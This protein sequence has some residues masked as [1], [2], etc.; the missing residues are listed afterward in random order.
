MKKEIKVSGHLEV[1]KGIYHMKL[2]WV[3]AEGKR[4]RKS[5]STELP[6]RGNKKRAQDMLIDFQREQEAEL[7]AN[8][9]SA[10]DI[11]F[12]DYMKQWLE[13]MKLQIRPTTYSGYH[14]NV[15]GVIIPYFKPMKLKLREVTPKHIQDFYTKQR[16]RVKGTTVK[17]YHAN[18]HKAFKDARKL[19]LIDSNPMECV[20]PP[21]KEPYHGQTYTVE[22]AQKILVLI[23]DTIFEI[24]ITMM[25]FYGLRREEAIG[26]KWQNID[27]DNDTF[28]IAHTVTETKVDG[29]LQM[30]KEDLTKN[31]SSYRSL[32]LVAPVKE[33]LL[34]KKQSIQEYRK[35]FRR[36]Y[37]RE[38]SDY[39]CV[40]EIGEL[41]KPRT[42]SDNFKRIIRQNKI[43]NLR[44][45][46]CRHTAASLML[47]NGVNMKQ[48]QM[49]LG[50]S[51][52]ATTANIYSHLDYS[53]KIPATET[54]KEIIYGKDNETV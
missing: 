3:S 44:L 2:S 52:Y 21:K 6:E 33:L 4:Q 50:H 32:P 23:G 9:N 7:V 19:Q 46:D 10:K 30:V 53:D 42:L 34:E 35:L 37:Y 28:L 11:L 48:I 1:I 47:K 8:G 26:L 39:V 38:D 45:Y 16:Q 15:Y 18:I 29:H 41:I 20:D 51:D 49:I 25:L 13:K 54:M 27:F 36:S 5:K 31:S 24:P 17:S 22:E 14:D 43:R 40:N 12:T